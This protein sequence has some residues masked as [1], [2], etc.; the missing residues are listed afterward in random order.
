MS[1]R[2]TTRASGT[3]TAWSSAIGGAARDWREAVER[4]LLLLL[5]P[6]REAHAYVP[7][8]IS[9]SSQLVRRCRRE[10]RPK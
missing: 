2:K 4:W 3:G 8:P 7:V 10:A 6:R 1:F 5:P 9:V